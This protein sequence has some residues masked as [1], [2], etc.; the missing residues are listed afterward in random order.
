M[1]ILSNI[2]GPI[3]TEKATSQQKD[4]K[5]QVKVAPHATKIQVAKAFKA[6]YGVD[7][8]KVNAMRT[9]EKFR[10]GKNRMMNVKKHAF[11]KMVLTVKDKKAVDLAK[12]N[13][14]A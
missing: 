3:I 4:G 9:N 6:L 1:E 8:I 2:T 13:I 7:V 14:K 12:P 11:K 10:V 5:Y